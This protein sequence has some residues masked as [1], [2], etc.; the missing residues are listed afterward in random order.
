[1]GSTLWVNISNHQDMTAG[2]SPCSPFARATH[3]EVTPFLTHTWRKLRPAKNIFLFY[4]LRLKR[5]N[6]RFA[7]QASL[8]LLERPMSTFEAKGLNIRREK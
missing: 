1:M 6:K 4:K 7:A 2:F 3:F 8:E 5:I